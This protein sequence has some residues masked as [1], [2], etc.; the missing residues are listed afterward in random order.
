MV[1]HLLTL[2]LMLTVRKSRS[3]RLIVL[4]WSLFVIPVKR[5]Q[6]KI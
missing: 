3:I 4:P 5:Q 1:V 2:I 6:F